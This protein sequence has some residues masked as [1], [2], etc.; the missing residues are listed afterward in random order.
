MERKVRDSSKMLPHCFRAWADSSKPLKCQAG[1]AGHVRSHR[2]L[3][4]EEKKAEAPCSAPTSAGLKRL[5][6]LGAGAG[7]AHRM[8]R[9]KGASWSANQP[10][11][12]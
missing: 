2:A 4:D 9:G 7:Q 11:L 3:F 5:E 12:L 1:A 8:P 6:G 10:P